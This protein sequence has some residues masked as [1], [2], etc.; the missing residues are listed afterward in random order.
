MAAFPLPEGLRRPKGRIV[1]S[2]PSAIL[3][4]GRREG[5]LERISL[6]REAHSAL[7]PDGKESITPY[8]RSQ[9]HSSSGTPP[10]STASGTLGLARGLSFLFLSS[11]LFVY[12]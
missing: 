9:I 6:A 10:A 4:S 2:K 12:T 5:G 7:Q 1:G 8:G 11:N 3:G